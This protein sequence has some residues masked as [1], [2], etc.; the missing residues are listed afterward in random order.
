MVEPMARWFEQE[1][2]VVNVGLPAFGEAIRAAGGAALDVQWAPPGQGDPEVARR[3]A[4][5]I[6]HPAHRGRQ[7][8]RPTTPISRPS[9][10]SRASAWPAS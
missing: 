9:R 10:C 4:G 5:L 1:L 2:Q 6:N 7:S 8:D 3:L